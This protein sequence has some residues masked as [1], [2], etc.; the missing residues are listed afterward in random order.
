MY[1]PLLT[2]SNIPSSLACS[3]LYSNTHPSWPPP[4]RMQEA[5]ES[6]TTYSP[7]IQHCQ[8]CSPLF[9]ATDK[10]TKDREHQYAEEEK[11]TLCQ[12]KQQTEAAE[13]SRGCSCLLQPRA[14]LLLVPDTF[15]FIPRTSMQPGRTKQ[16]NNHEPFPWNNIIVH[17]KIQKKSNSYLFPKSEQWSCPHKDVQHARCNTKTTWYHTVQR[18]QHETKYT[19]DTAGCL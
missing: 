7:S 1:I 19:S 3:C 18:R 10:Q 8:L 16:G 17:R 5:R 12:H 11:W 13:F 6:I 4:L 9:I 15:C 2:V 14:E